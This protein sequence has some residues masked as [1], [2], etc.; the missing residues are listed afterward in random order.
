MDYRKKGLIYYTGYNVEFAGKYKI[1]NP[2]NENIYLS[3][4]FPLNRP[5][6]PYKLTAAK[7]KK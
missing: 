4:I 7:S 5:W 6:Q 2:E 3:L 1:N